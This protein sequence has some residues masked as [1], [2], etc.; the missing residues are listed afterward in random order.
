MRLLELPTTCSAWSSAPSCRRGTRAPCYVPDQDGRRRPAREIARPGCGA[1]GRAEGAVG[2]RQAEAADEEAAV[3]PALAKRVRTAAERLTAAC[4]GTRGRIEI[5]FADEYELAELAE[6]S[7]VL[8]GRKP[9]RRPARCTYMGDSGRTR[10]FERV[11]RR[12]CQP[13]RGWS[14]NSR[15]R[16]GSEPFVTQVVASG[17]LDEDTRSAITELAGDEAS[18]RWRSRTAVQ[19]WRERPGGPRAWAIVDSN[20]DL[21][22]I[23][24][25]L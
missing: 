17:E 23:R 24:V 11:R 9:N 12:V 6:R 15:A 3:D 1:R 10:T 2:R 14:A 16:A 21:R 20:H 8:H 7:S 22:L 19:H 5:Q 4:V 25:A 18:R 13:P